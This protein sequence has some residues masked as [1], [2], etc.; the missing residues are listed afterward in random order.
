MRQRSLGGVHQNQRPIHHVE[1]AFD[2]AAEIGV[3]GGV[4][5]VDPGVLPDQ[6]GR[7][8]EDGDAAL[9]FEVVGIHGALDDA[10]VVAKRARLLQQAVNQGGFA[11]VDV[12]NDGD[13]AQVHMSVPGI[14]GGPLEGAEKGAMG[15]AFVRCI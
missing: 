2:L 8:G 12:G 10:L 15:P 9:A 7:L 11:M 6:R 4:D 13:I 5:D 14:K 1:D 3:A